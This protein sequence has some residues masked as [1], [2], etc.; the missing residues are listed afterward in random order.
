MSFAVATCSFSGSRLAAKNPGLS[1]N[2]N[3][4]AGSNT[5]QVWWLCPTSSGQS[6]NSIYSS[7]PLFV[8]GRSCST[9]SGITLP[10]SSPQTTIAT[11]IPTSRTM[12]A[13]IRNTYT[14]LPTVHSTEVFLHHACLRTLLSLVSPLHVMRLL[15]KTHYS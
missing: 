14:F 10:S 4:T 1:L 5:T 3:L 6:S 9:I 7:A 13:M 2:L 15:R 8:D 11:R 12:T